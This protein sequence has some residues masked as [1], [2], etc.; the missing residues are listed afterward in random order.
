MRHDKGLTTQ[1]GWQNKDAYRRSLSATKRRQ[2]GRLRT[3]QIRTKD[4]SERNLQSALGECPR[5][6][7][8]DP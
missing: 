5:C 4:A 3:W 6:A 1:I 8:L 7:T 2:L